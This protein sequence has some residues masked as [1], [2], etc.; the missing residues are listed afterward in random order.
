MD[1]EAGKISKTIGYYL[2]FI[3]LGLGG[4]ILGPTLPDLAENTQTPLSGISF[5]FTAHSLGYLLGSIQSGR[6]YDR[7][8]GHRIM[9][10]GLMLLAAMLALVPL[11]P[12]LWLLTAV[13]LILGMAASTLDVG[14]NTL[15]VW[16]HRQQ[17]GPFMNG[18]HFFFGVGAFLSP[19]IVAQ[20]ML[21]R[22]NLTWAYWVLALLV[23]LPVFWLI[24]L[25]SPTHESSSGYD[26]SRRV[27]PLL[28][29]LLVLFFV[30][31]VGG[32]M[33]FGGW[34]YTYAVK[35]GL[36]SETAAAYLTSAFW[37]AL[38][39]GRL[40]SVPLA[41]RLRPQII[42]FGSL[43][44]CLISVSVILLWSQSVTAVWL[45]AVGMGMSIASL[46]PGTFSLAERYMAITGRVSGWFLAGASLGGMSLPWLIGQLFERVG[47]Q[48]TMVA[49]LID[50]TV[51]TGVFIVALFLLT[52]L[53]LS[54]NK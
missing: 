5:L 30:L 11:I 47:P 12:L 53:S 19:I 2:T 28:L 35:A 22:G 36:S 40:L 51:A 38:T 17:V 41:A 43:L 52:R 33:S 37:G 13:W 18:L 39:L 42:M 25:P 3:A 26:N 48:V 27:S 23:F 54:K 7:K 20:V 44:G 45:G 16:V 49:I 46:F 31:N 15:L 24:R 29:G 21:T 10:I 1:S 14:G 6:W 32:E 9:T 4:A 8:P 50:F 34:I